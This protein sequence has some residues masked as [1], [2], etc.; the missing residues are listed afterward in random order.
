MKVHPRQG[1]LVRFAT[2]L[3]NLLSNFVGSAQIGP[4]VAPDPNVYAIDI[5][6]PS[7]GQPIS[8]HRKDR[9]AAIGRLYCPSAQERQDA[10][11]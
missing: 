4:Y 2:G 10:A 8:E 11:G 9:T 5:A 7:C 6:C 3:D 1:R